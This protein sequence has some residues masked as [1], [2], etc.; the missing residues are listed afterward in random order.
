MSWRQR[1][2]LRAS[3][4]T[5]LRLHRFHHRIRAHYH[6]RRH[7]ILRAL[8]PSRITIVAH[9]DAPS[10]PPPAVVCLPLASTARANLGS[11]SFLRPSLG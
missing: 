6:L 1:P 11:P 3:S 5:H 10:S 2:S 8:P 4:P 9:H 7:R